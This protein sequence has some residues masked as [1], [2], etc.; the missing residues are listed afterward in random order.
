MELH[1]DRGNE[2]PYIQ[3]IIIIH[4]YERNYLSAVEPFTI[5]M[6][7]FHLKCMAKVPFTP[8]SQ[9][10]R[11]LLNRIHAIYAAPL[12]PFTL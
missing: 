3:N 5:H 11:I 9:T 8:A 7:S 12:I 4:Y 10:Y 1:G 2:I 6:N